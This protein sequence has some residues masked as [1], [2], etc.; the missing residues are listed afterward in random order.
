MLA[1]PLQTPEHC[2]QQIYRQNPDQ[3][4]LPEPQI[5]GAVM[6]ACDIRVARKKI[7]SIFENVNPGKDNS[8]EAD[9][10]K[11]SAVARP[12]RHANESRQRACSSMDDSQTLKAMTAFDSELARRSR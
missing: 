11:K 5:T 1:L 2:H 8:D 3:D 4:D 9:T 6:I 12:N 10:E 7:F